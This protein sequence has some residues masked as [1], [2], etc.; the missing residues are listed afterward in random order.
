[1]IWI[2][3][4]DFEKLCFNFTRELMTYNQAIPNYETRN[5]ELLESALAVPQQTFGG[6]ELYPTITKKASTL[7][8]SLIKNHP[9]QNGNKRIAVMTLL[10]YLGINNKW[11]N[12]DPYEFYKL[13]IKVAA[14]K[15]EQKEKIIKLIEKIIDKK[16]K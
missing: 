4:K 13:A 1:M 7:F 9:F 10:V 5:K 3:A 11:L 6:I 16:I 8:Y 2:T 14:S 15:P 12:I